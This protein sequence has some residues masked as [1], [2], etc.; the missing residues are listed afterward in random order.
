MMRTLHRPPVLAWAAT[1][2]ASL[3][4]A[5][6]AQSGLLAGATVQRTVSVLAT[7]ENVGPDFDLSDAD[8]PASGVVSG[9]DPV[10][11]AVSRSA[12]A[13]VLP[14]VAG[15]GGASAAA[16]A[17]ATAVR[18]PGGGSV[19]VGGGAEA[20]ADLAFPGSAYPQQRADSRATASF[21]TLL[22]FELTREADYTLSSQTLEAF[23]FFTTPGIDVVLKNEDTG[24]VLFADTFGRFSSLDPLEELS[25]SGVLAAGRYELSLRG[26]AER[27][28]LDFTSSPVG[29]TG[30]VAFSVVPEPAC[31]AALLL[32][33]GTLCRRRD[34]A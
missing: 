25:A 17:T 19:R 20:V 7:A 2:A 5:A 12:S 34:R 23:D 13:E 11:P 33:L 14:P 9:F 28:G 22:R 15:A 32:G 6:S 3:A 29:A 16:S 1:I 10:L 30:F 26:E 27:R 8:T 31:A 18:L 21:E 24:A 4:P